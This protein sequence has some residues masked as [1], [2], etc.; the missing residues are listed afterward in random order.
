M[1][2]ATETQLHRIKFRH[3]DFLTLPLED[4]LFFVRLAHITDD[5]RHV[6]YLAAMAERGTHSDLADERKL[7]IHQLL[8]SVRLVYSL[9]YEGWS[10]IKNSWSDK[11]LGKRWDPRL[12]DNGRKGLDSL[13]RYFGPANLCRTIRHDFGFHYGPEPL[14]E[15]VAHLSDREDEIITGKHSGNIFYAFAEEI[16]SL[17]MLQAAAPEGGVKLWDQNASETDIRA[18]AIRLYEGFKPIH[19]AFDAFAN[20]VLVR[21]VK[22]LP[23]KTERFT[24]P[25]VT[26]LSE[27]RPILFVQEPAALIMSSADSSKRRRSV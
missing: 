9:L 23:Y 6:L 20:N 21:I 15:P 1:E 19:N 22:S 7:A 2:K 27:I 16:R 3:S 5:L 14:K 17:A 26:K 4:Q 13:R 25:R 10:V 12:S 18:A 11:A 8:F 24:A